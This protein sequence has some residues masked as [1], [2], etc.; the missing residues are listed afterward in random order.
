MH[1]LSA[2]TVVLQ[3][4]PICDLPIQKGGACPVK[5]KHGVDVS[6][7]VGAKSLTDSRTTALHTETFT[8]DE[9]NRGPGG[10]RQIFHGT[11]L[12]DLSKER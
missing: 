10:S 9:K 11:V 3:M 2:L 5:A 1:F 12:S 4:Q 6:L 8:Q 7:Q